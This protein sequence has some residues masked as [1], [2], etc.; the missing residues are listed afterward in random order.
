VAPVVGNSLGGKGALPQS[1]CLSFQPQL[2]PLCTP[3]AKPFSGRT[4]KLLV[5]APDDGLNNN[6]NNNNNNSVLSDGNAM[7]I[8]YS[9]KKAQAGI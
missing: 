2:L 6:N 7:M 1:C 4:A 5:A 3:Q 9:F 8:A